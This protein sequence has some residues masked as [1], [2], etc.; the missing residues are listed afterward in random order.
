MSN[1]KANLYGFIHHIKG[2]SGFEVQCYATVPLFSDFHRM[3]I[4]LYLVSTIWSSASATLRDPQPTYLA[5]G[6]KKKKYF[7][8]IWFLKALGHDGTKIAQT[9]QR[10]LE[11]V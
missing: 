4:A 2:K 5:W 11:F 6:D 3:G 10:Y 9:D 7:A 8:V 1:I